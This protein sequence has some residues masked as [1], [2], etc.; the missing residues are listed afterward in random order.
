MK[1]NNKGLS[2]FE[3]IGVI[4]IIGVIATI[5]VPSVT[6]YINR[7]E[8]TTFLSYEKSIEDAATNSVLECIGNNS[9]TCEVP[10]KGKINVVKLQGLIDEGYIDPLNLGDKGSCDAEKSFVRIENRGNLNYK[11]KV[12]LYCD[13][14]VTDDDLCKE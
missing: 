13:N 8:L 6:K 10:E 9:H 11:F 5:A 3:M 12:C 7:G 1:L 4:V 2:L 14:Y